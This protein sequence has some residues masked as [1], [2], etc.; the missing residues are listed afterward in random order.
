MRRILLVTLLVQAT[1]FGVRPMVSY[2][3][4]ELGGDPWDLGI[5]A[6]SFSLLSLLI[7]VPVGRWID[8]KGESWFILGG[9][10]VVAVSAGS[11]ALS[12]SIP[13]LVITQAL[14]G[15]GQIMNVVGIQAW[16]ANTSPGGTADQRF[17]AF[18]VAVSIG[19]LV[20]PGGG[21]LLA[22]WPSPTAA[23]SGITLVMVAGAA[24]SLVAVAVSVPLLREN[25]PDRSGRG[26]TPEVVGQ[27]GLIWGIL[28]LPSM[29]Q[30]ILTS[31][32]VLTCVDILS[33][34]LPLYGETRGLSIAGVGLLLAVRGGAALLSRLVMGK[35]IRRYGRKRVLVVSTS[36][37]AALLMVFPLTDEMWLLIGLMTVIGFGLGLGQPITLAWVAGQV[38][39]DRRGAA[40]G[41]RLSANRLGQ[42]VIPLGVGA[43]AGP[44]GVGSVFL[45][46]SVLLAISGATSANAA[47]GPAAPPE[48]QR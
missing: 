45:F 6:A 18:T 9:A 23:L 47:F 36:V 38:A 48:P 16:V 15:G 44:L 3:A 37:P 24:V 8:L 32:T 31:L 42:V 10:A 30:A 29:P 35:L 43:V 41:L 12:Q 5:I 27:R 14:L 17:G 34:Y 21:G 4:L 11:M 39:E 40:L 33:I 7:A 13:A 22:S 26:V 19:Q 20:G 2:R 1:L 28:A 46:M 25:R